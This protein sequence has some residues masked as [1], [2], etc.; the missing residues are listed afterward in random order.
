MK[1]QSAIITIVLIALGLGAWFS[2]QTKQEA[3]K[4]TAGASWDYQS[5][6]GRHHRYRLRYEGGGAQAN[7]LGKGESAMLLVG[8]LSQT[9]RAT[10][11]G[12]IT[13]EWAFS[14][15]DEIQ[16][17]HDQKEILGDKAALSKHFA[18]GFIQWTLDAQGHIVER[19][20]S[21]DIGAMAEQFLQ[22]I[23]DELELWPAA[24]PK[25]TQEQGGIIGRGPVRYQIA[26]TSLGK[27]KITRSRGSYLQVYA[28][29]APEA[30]KTAKIQS[31]GSLIV[32]SSGVIQTFSTTDFLEAVITTEDAVKMTTQS[33]LSLQLIEESKLDANRQ[34]SIATRKAV[35]MRTVHER[36]K[37]EALKARVGRMTK[38]SFLADM[39]K[40]SG[41]GQMPN[42][43]DWL[44]QAL[45]ILRL[46]PELALLFPELLANNAHSDDGTA[47]LIDLLT[48]TGT[49]EAQSALRTMLAS[50]LLTERSN[51]ED[52]LQR[53]VFLENPDAESVR[54]LEKIQ[55]TAALESTQAMAS[56]GLGKAAR[57]L[58]A[59]GGEAK[60]EAIGSEIMR[61]AQAATDPAIR[62]RYI[63]GMDN[64]QLERFVPDLLNETEHENV[65]VQGAAIDALSFSS[66]PAVRRRLMDL[67]GDDESWLR[68]RSLAALSE[69]SFNADEVEHLAQLLRDKKFAPVEYRRLI[70]VARELLKK[71]PGLSRKIT[72]AIAGLRPKLATVRREIEE[73]QLQLMVA[74]GR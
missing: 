14:Q 40:L 60:A 17:L 61:R 42:H 55:S 32:D 68:K 63:V 45:G 1:R 52:L 12:A 37:R 71:D 72:E 64:A 30:L 67:V 2:S 33:Q 69:K 24:T 15:I 9:I 31:E 28:I 35:D 19:R 18:T 7:A 66:S 47:L 56:L 16:I 73:L 27:P 43:G 65:S 62:K 4:A 36:A 51:Y 74:D 46:H 5:L 21:E 20:A 25:W 10:K 57:V 22:I 26:E 29:A 70:R 41:I 23:T 38:A 49:K 53:M 6:A 3:G 48:L 50:P 58:H 39:K 13:I 34:P 11:A 59:N 44:W 54:F 8:E